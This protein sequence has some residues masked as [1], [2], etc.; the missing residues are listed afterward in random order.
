MN[1]ILEIELASEELEGRAEQLKENKDQLVSKEQMIQQVMDKLSVDVA[2]IEKLE[3]NLSDIKEK[4]KEVDRKI[5]V[6]SSQIDEIL[7]QIGATEGKYQ[8]S[9][10]TIEMAEQ[11]GCD[12]GNSKEIVIE[13]LE[14]LNECRKQ[15]DKI[16]DRLES[17]SNKESVDINSV[18]MRKSME[19]KEYN[20]MMDK[21]VIAHGEAIKNVSYMSPEQQH[22][23]H[24]EYTENVERAKKEYAEQ[25][26]R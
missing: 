13:R 21:M 24:A 20:A 9:M 25:Y 5:E 11:M 7:S 23:E 2:I 1:Q 16:A 3:S 18:A 15:I 19:P 10:E 12:V 14:V 22:E 6:C 8:S 17:V 26:R 4:D